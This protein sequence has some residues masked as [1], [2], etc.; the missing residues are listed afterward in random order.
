MLLATSATKN[1][2]WLT[3][4]NQ[5]TVIWSG[6]QLNCGSTPTTVISNGGLWQMTGDNLFYNPYGCPPMT[7]TNS[8]TLRKSAGS[9]TSSIND[10]S[11]VNQASGMIQSDTGILQLSTPI[12]NAAGILRLHGG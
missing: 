12:P 1:L 5:G 8:G 6:G 9:G 3:L 2:H 10:F 7:W 4:I 11:F